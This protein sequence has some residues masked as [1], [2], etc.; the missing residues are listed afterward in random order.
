MKD[1]VNRGPVLAYFILTFAISW[2][3][4]LLI[5]GGPGAIPTPSDEAMEL[6][7]VA[8]LVMVAGPSIAGILLTALVYG[9]AGLGEFGSQ[10]ARF[11]VGARW[12]A[13]AILT[14][15]VLVGL[16]LFVFSRTSPMFIPDIVTADDKVTLLI[17]GI[18]AGLTAGIIEE[19]G[20]TGF[21]VPQLRRRYGILATGLIVGF[22]WGIW[23][24]L[25]TF[26]GSG[27]P[28]G[29]FDPDLLLPPLIFYIGVLPA[30]RVLLV[31]VYDHT[32]SLPVVMLMHASLTANTN[33]ILSPPVRGVP[34]MVYYL[35]LTAVMWGAAAVVAVANRRRSN[36][37]AA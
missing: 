7:P 29:G 10:L 25:V 2:G 5:I 3:G 27:N 34:F 6:L 21:A 14:A 24:F 20:W 36:S 33:F 4:I 19:L 17:S 11:R 23:H 8:I 26:W 30:Y 12:Y 31:W 1:F 37:G 32:E 9:R 22:V 18:A 28:S 15:P 16:V 35:V 13:I